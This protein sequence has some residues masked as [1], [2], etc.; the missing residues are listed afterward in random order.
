M[1]MAAPKYLPFIGLLFLLSSAASAKSLAW[2][3]DQ[4]EIKR[5]FAIGID[6]MGGEIDYGF[7]KVWSAEFIFLIDKTSTDLGTLTTF[8]PGLRVNRHFKT[9]QRLQ[10]YAGFH[11]AYINSSL[12]SSGYSSSTHEYSTTGEAFG[13]YGGIQLYLLRRL[14]ITL[15][16][17]PYYLL[18]KE[19]TSQM[20]GNGLDF[21]INS[22]VKFFI[23]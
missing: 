20:T 1:N 22:A 8:A 13:I 17:G 9:E 7:K 12:K 15:D 21:V 14:S 3:S 16:M 4:P 11:G 23:F 2:F 19:R 6:Y 18:L 10:Y 5:K